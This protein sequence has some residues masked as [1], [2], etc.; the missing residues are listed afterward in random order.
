MSSRRNR[1]WCHLHLPKFKSGDAECVSIT[2][3][4]KPVRY[5]AEIVLRDVEFVV[6][7]GDRARALTEGRKNVHAYVTGLEVSAAPYYISPESW[8]KAIYR[9]ADGPDFYDSVS[10]DP[11]TWATYAVLSGKDVWYTKEEA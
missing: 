3:A 5:A 7:K 10:G 9:P 4:G 2:Q 8:R 1:V 11:I 6:Q